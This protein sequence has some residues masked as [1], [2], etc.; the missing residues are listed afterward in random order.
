MKRVAPAAERNTAPILEVL[1]R[2]VPP[3]GL[4]LEVASGT[5]QHALAFAR[6]FPGLAVQPTEPQAAGRES[7]EAYRAEAALP[8][9]RAP[10]ALD[11]T[12]A[13]WPLTSADVVVAIN[14][15]HISPWDATLGLLDG[16]ARTLPAGG[17]LFLYG[18]YLVDGAPTTESNQAFDAS[19][20]QRDPR[21]GLR[22]LQTV[23]DA[24]AD[25]GLARLEVVPMPAHNFSVV[26]RRGPDPRNSM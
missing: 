10:L 5:G 1:G 22:D 25:R 2:H 4:L 3:A 26:F 21:W 19:L 8:N 20:R 14:M 11:V 17:I 23:T 7:I 9:L 6:A 16:A 24:A 13:V 15:I 12:Q 18:P